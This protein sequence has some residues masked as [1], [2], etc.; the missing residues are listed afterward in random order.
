M[1]AKIVK[2]Y[3]MTDEDKRYF[4]EMFGKIMIWMIEKRSIG[5]MANELNLLPYQ[6]EYNIDEALYTLRN[7]VGRWRYFKMLFIK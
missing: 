1:S 5:Y 2:T 6:V 7:Q 4:S 3:Q